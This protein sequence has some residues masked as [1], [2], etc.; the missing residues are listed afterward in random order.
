MET[1]LKVTM[2]P[3]VGVQSEART[4]VVRAME[5]AFKYRQAFRKVLFAFHMLQRLTPLK[6]IIVDLL[7]YRRWYARSTFL[8][9]PADHC[10]GGASYQ[11]NHS[12]VNVVSAT[13]N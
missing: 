6:D 3:I 7:V 9:D 4:D 5:I 8:F 2:N 1:I 13:T 11:L 10:I 12:N